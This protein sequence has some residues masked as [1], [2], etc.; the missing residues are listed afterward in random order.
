MGS[1]KVG[2]GDRDAETI[3]GSEGGSRSA[4]AGRVNTGEWY[5]G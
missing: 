1:V 3:T 4:A 2:R 5:V